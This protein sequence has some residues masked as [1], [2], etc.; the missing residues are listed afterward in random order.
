MMR[1][2]YASAVATSG[3]KHA[4]ASSTDLGFIM[5]TGEPRLAT[6]WLPET[7]CVRKWRPCLLQQSCESNSLGVSEIS[8]TP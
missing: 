6:S 7:K 2:A 8:V 3:S 5:G 4:T 1:M